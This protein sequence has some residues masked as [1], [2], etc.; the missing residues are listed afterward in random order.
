VPVHTRQPGALAVLPPLNSYRLDS[1]HR[2]RQSVRGFASNQIQKLSG[3][4]R[5][6]KMGFTV[7]E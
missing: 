7:R 4:E 3:I 1:R 2:A 5:G 6:R